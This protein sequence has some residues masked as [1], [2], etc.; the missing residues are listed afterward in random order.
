MST[1]QRH[2]STQAMEEFS[3][4]ESLFEKDFNS[5]VDLSHFASSS[6]LPADFDLSSD[7]LPQTQAHDGCELP[8]D[9]QHLTELT[10]G[11]CEDNASGG[12]SSYEPGNGMCQGP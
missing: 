12:L 10:N 6:H 4:I 7:P 8:R 1:F 3:D 11:R 5:F 2:E 9:V